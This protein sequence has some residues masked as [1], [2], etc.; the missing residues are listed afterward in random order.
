MLRALRTIWTARCWPKTFRSKSIFTTGRMRVESEG[1]IC[2]SP[3]SGCS[4]MAIRGSEQ[5]LP[6]VVNQQRTKLRGGLMKLNGIYGNQAA[7]RR[8][9]HEFSWHCTTAFCKALGW[10]LMYISRDT[11][12]VLNSHLPFLCPLAHFVFI[13]IHAS[14][15]K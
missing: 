1:A 5:T 12:R 8:I 15:A 13:A 14:V 2:S 10:G 11:M 7:C 9:C 4:W 6:E 3:F